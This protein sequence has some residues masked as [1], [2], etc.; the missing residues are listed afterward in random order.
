MPVL[1]PLLHFLGTTRILHI[2][3]WKYADTK[4]GV[5]THCY[6]LVNVLRDELK[7]AVRSTQLTTNTAAFI[8]FLLPPSTRLTTPATSQMSE[9]VRHFKLH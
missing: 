7:Y 4:P 2:A 5:Q 9:E 6:K 3:C 1:L 8:F